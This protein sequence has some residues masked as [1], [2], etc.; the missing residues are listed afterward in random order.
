MEDRAVVSVAEAKAYFDKNPDKF[1]I[2][3]SLAVQ[4]I[5][6]FLLPN[7]TPDQLKEVRKRAEAAYKQA[8]TAREL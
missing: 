3:D 5:R 8:K 4:T 7:A 1:R 2:P 6:F